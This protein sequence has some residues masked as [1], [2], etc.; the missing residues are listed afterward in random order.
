VYHAHL[1]GGKGIPPDLT[2]GLAEQVP[3]DVFLSGV[4]E[5]MRVERGAVMM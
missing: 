3:R 1:G 5:Q 4:V 2:R